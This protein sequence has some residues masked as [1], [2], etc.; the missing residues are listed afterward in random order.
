MPAADDDALRTELRRVV[1]RLDSM[2]VNRADAA[3]GA[4][5]DAAALIVARTRELVDD[6][7][8]DAVLPDLG[9]QGLGSML[10]VVGRDYLHAVGRAPGTDVTPVLECLTGLRRSLP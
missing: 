6:M 10:A 8:P 9:P 4:C 7:P 2:P 5:R 3:T 1:D